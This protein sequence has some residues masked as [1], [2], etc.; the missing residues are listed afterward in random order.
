MEMD[1]LDETE[2]MIIVQI[3][4][5]WDIG[6]YVPFNQNLYPIIDTKNISVTRVRK[7]QV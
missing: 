3:D 7:M 5:L 1:G 4:M 6:Y 2:S